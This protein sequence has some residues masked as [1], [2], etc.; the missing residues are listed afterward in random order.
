M[1]K[2]FKKVVEWE[3]KP[4]SILIVTGLFLILLGSILFI[5]SMMVSDKF[6]V[7]DNNL[8]NL[9][10][11]FVSSICFSVIGMVCFGITLVMNNNGERRKVYYQEVKEK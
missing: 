2:R 4:N 1:R 10:V 7:E 11:F 3:E 6:L 8:S 5:S 9:G